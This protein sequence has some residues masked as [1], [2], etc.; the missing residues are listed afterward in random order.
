MEIHVRPAAPPE[1]RDWDDFKAFKVVAH[2]FGSGAELHRA[3]GEVGRTAA[4]DGHVFVRVEWLQEHAKSAPD[5]ADWRRRLGEMF[6]TAAR[7]GWLDEAGQIRAHIEQRD[8]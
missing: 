4:D 3:L 2:G 5:P 7:H 1:L 8:E 6:D